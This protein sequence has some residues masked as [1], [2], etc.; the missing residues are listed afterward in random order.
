MTLYPGAVQNPKLVFKNLP[1]LTEPPP[2][3]VGHWTGGER[4][5]EPV[6]RVLVDRKCSA[7]FNLDLPGVLTQYA[8]LD[9]RC[10]HAGPV[11]NKGIGVEASNRGFPDK[12]G[13]APR[14]FDIV[15][16]HGATV[17]AVRFTDAQLAAWV[18]LCEW[19]AAKYGWPRQVPNVLRKLTPAE[20]ARWRGALEHLHLSRQKADSGG[21]FMRALVDAGWSAVDP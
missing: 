6:F 20:A 18:A 11:G 14:P 4:G 8:G 3:A 10:S 12:A 2:F 15:K 1:L 19:L 5:A 16:I 13:K 9:R 17:R 7:H 21:H